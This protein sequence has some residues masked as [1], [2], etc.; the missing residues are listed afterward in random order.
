MY[1][2]QS[3]ESSAGSGQI[4]EEAVSVPEESEMITKD[5]N[6]VNVDFYI[7]YQIVDPIKAYVNSEN[8]ISIL[9]N[10]A[11]SYIRDTCLLYTSYSGARGSLHSAPAGRVPPGS[12]E[13]V[14]GRYLHYFGEP[15]GPSGHDRA[16]RKRFQGASHRPAADRGLL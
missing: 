1:K 3:Y 2:R 11:Q 13:N 6:F 12:S 7:E 5:F 4:A 8:N 10:L 9:K 15:G 14:S 16:L